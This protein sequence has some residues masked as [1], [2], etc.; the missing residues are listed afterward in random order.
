MSIW[1]EET[2]P[3]RFCVCLTGFTGSPLPKREIFSFIEI[4]D[5]W[6]GFPTQTPPP[7]SACSVPDRIQRKF[8]ENH[9]YSLQTDMRAHVDRFRTAQPVIEK[10]LPRSAMRASPGFGKQYSFSL[11]ND[12][13]P[14]FY[15]IFTSQSYYMQLSGENQ[16]FFKNSAVPFILCAFSCQPAALSSP[17]RI[18]SSVLGV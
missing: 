7:E 10:H 3:A 9:E 6:A 1:Q 8:K 4:D 13:A 14:A 15:H 17:A 2:I 16:A 5:I 18:S 11:P 12:I